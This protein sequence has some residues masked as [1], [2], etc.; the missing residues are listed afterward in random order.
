[1]NGLPISKSNGIATC[2]QPC[3]LVSIAVQMT[4]L[5]ITYLGHIIKRPSRLHLILT[6]VRLGVMTVLRVPR[7]IRLSHPS[8]SIPPGL[9]NH[10]SQQSRQSQ[11]IRTSFST[12]TPALNLP[13]PRTQSTTLIP[14]LQLHSLPSHSPC[15][16]SSA[17]YQVHR[18]V[19][20]GLTPYTT[21]LGLAL[22]CPKLASWLPLRILSSRFPAVMSRLGF[23]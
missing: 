2:H 19:F 1:M 14:S 21:R 10:T 5:H 4:L 9:T 20:H 8:S 12:R 7:L 22:P 3:A 23:L 17:C 15:Q 18:A 11:S 13:K 16:S 6:L